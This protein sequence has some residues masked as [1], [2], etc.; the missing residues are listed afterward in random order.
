MTTR[1][2][3]APAALPPE[4]EPC[5]ADDEE[6]GP[7]RDSVAPQGASGGRWSLPTKALA[8]LLLMA[9]V[10]LAVVPMPGRQAADVSRV[11]ELSEETSDSIPSEVS[12]EEFGDAVPTDLS[13]EDALSARYP[14]QRFA[15]FMPTDM[16]S[17]GFADAA[18][19]DFSSEDS[20]SLDGLHWDPQLHEFVDSS[21]KVA[22][23]YAGGT[24]LDNQ[25]LSGWPYTT[26]DDPTV[27]VY[28][29]V[30]HYISHA[31]PDDVHPSAPYDC[32]A[33][34]K[35]W[36]D[37]W[38]DGKKE[39]C[40]VKQKVGCPVT[41]APPKFDCHDGPDMNTS[42]W[43]D[44]RKE[45][46][47][48]RYHRGCEEENFTSYDCQTDS[49]VWESAWSL[50]QREWCC[51][52]HQV[53]C[54]PYNCKE[55]PPATTTAAPN[56][57][58]E[59][60]S[61]VSDASNASVG[62]SPAK[63]EWCCKH[64]RE[65]CPYDCAAGSWQDWPDE[66][67]EWC[68]D[69]QGLGCEHYT[70]TVGNGTTHEA[71][72]DKHKF[73]CCE[74][75]H[76][77]CDP[78]DCDYLTNR[79]R[80]Y[81]SDSKRSYCCLKESKGCV[82]HTTPIPYDCE[83][84]YAQWPDKW[85]KD[86]KEWCCETHLR[87]CPEPT[88]PTP[89]YSYDCHIPVGHSFEGMFIPEQKIWC[90]HHKNIGCDPFD[91]GYQYSRRDILWSNPK[92]HW[93]CS[94]A[95]LG[96][97]HTRP[98]HVIH[99]PHPSDP[100]DCEAGLAKWEIG[101]SDMKKGWCCK[102]KHVACK[103]FDCAF[104]Y[105]SR[106]T[107]WSVTKK[108]WCCQKENVGCESSSTHGKFDC[109][110]G[111]VKWE[112]GWSAAKKTWCCAHHQRACDKYNCHE[113]FNDRYLDWSREKRAFCCDK[114]SYACSH[115]GNWSHLGHGGAV[116]LHEHHDPTVSDKSGTVPELP[117]DVL[118]NLADH[119]QYF[120]SHGATSQQS[121]SSHGGAVVH[122]EYHAEQGSFGGDMEAYPGFK[123][124]NGKMVLDQ[125]TSSQSEEGDKLPAGFK[126]EHG[127]IT[128]HGKDISGANS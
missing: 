105:S 115:L 39:W 99:Y 117:P 106:E 43:T 32:S 90:C 120:G 101:W 89:S 15:H 27:H 59:N 84:D 86:K 46:C 52:T 2:L 97:S 11:Q 123:M 121:H 47:C 36:Q 28:H 53:A 62:W 104:E 29:T 33:G 91:C 96:C 70:C 18:P 114:Y 49:D 127:K 22:T 14:T 78:Y 68:C 126:M 113:D 1:A 82:G 73:W 58:D 76:V 111:F 37:G 50:E 88:T 13:S 35:N 21:G 8:A 54:D 57:S 93:C 110:A 124:Q 71:W 51:Y 5:R 67:K 66:Q 30:H 74:H 19:S 118:H 16:S 72:S 34:V 69:H 60:A 116:V 109:D 61:N 45:W 79:F 4:Y 128:Y 65:G 85:D 98:S 12:S 20:A 6:S 122:T 25:D 77:A 48:K 94:H 9:L 125:S 83:A 87:G 10:G 112:K 103:P 64:A 23:T 56:V 102:F 100:F 31:V 75:H 24:L 55:H 3:A 40:C 44:D 107:K 26:V 81:W 63:Q 42:N 80:Q 41:P 92:R 108:T 95:Q 17:E 119:F 38:S 7:F